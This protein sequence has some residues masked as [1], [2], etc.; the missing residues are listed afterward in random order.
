MEDIST[1]NHRENIAP[2]FDNI[3]I[4]SREIGR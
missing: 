2:L 3:N 1:D 4:K